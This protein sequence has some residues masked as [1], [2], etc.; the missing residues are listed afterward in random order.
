[1]TAEQALDQARAAEAE[2]MAGNYRVRYMAY[3]SRCAPFPGR[4]H[5]A[6]TQRAGIASERLPSGLQLPELQQRCAKT[7]LH[8]SLLVASRVQHLYDNRMWPGNPPH[9]FFPLMVRLDPPRAPVLCNVRYGQVPRLGGM[10]PEPRHNAL[11][12]IGGE[13]DPQCLSLDL[14]ANFIQRCI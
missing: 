6:G 2:I 5:F 7:I 4:L 14:R 8:C 11:P 13:L 12:Q 10:V 1:V 9:L 3:R